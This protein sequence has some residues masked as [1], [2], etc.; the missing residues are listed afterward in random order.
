MPAPSIVSLALA[1]LAFSGPSWKSLPIV[2]P[3]GEKQWTGSYTVDE[4]ALKSVAWKKP[5][6]AYDAAA[7]TGRKAAKVIVIIYDPVLESLGGKT[8][9]EN[10]KA[11][12]PVEYS[13]I[14]ANVIREASW[15]YVNYESVDVVRIDGYPIKVDGF[16]YTDETFL[17][18][19]KTQKWQP[20]TISYRKVFEENGLI[21]RCKKE[22]ITELWL[23]GCG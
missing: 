8:M 6:F 12:D 14:L 7:A 21:D 3:T 4:S 19:R 22:G 2:A 17:E 23:W 18:V 1:A 10:L 20:A 5:A 9:I 11:I 13:H 15:G 16:R